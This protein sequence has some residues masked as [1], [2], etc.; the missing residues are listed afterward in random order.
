[1]VMVVA[2]TSKFTATIADLPSRADLKA[3]K[4]KNGENNLPSSPDLTTGRL[5]GG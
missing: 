4:R 3:K 1:M 5:R 2:V